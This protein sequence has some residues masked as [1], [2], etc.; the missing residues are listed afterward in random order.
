MNIQIKFT[1]LL[2]PLQSPESWLPSQLNL[3]ASYFSFKV[4]IPE[5]GITAGKPWYT[6]H[7]GVCI[8]KAKA[9]KYYS[10]DCLCKILLL[11]VLWELYY[12]PECMWILYHFEKEK[13]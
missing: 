7:Q 9:W 8:S 4:Q 13:I 11:Y 6:K 2:Y 3:S 10:R 1:L 5:M 12:T